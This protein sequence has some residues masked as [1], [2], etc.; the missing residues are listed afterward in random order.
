MEVF[1]V[2]YRAGIKSGYSGSDEIRLGLGGN[3][4]SLL[5]IIDS[6]TNA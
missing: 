2:G 3:E 5:V 1:N 4:G 6:L